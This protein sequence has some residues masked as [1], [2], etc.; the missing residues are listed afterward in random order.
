MKRHCN[1]HGPGVPVLY[2][3]AL[4]SLFTGCAGYHRYLPTPTERALME[5]K[6]ELKGNPQSW[7]KIKVL[8][9]EQRIERAAYLVTDLDW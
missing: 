4:M 7:D 1:P 5:A 8:K 3:F 6:P 2:L 9:P